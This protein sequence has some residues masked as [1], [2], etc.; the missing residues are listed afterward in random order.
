MSTS[1]IT[2]TIYT[3]SLFCFRREFN[4]RSVH[5]LTS[6]QQPKKYSSSVKI[7]DSFPHPTAYKY[8]EE[9]WHQQHGASFVVINCKSSDIEYPEH[10]TPLSIKCAFGGKEYYH[11]KNY[12]LAVT[13]ETFLILNEGTTYRSSIHSENITESFTLNFTKENIDQVSSCHQYETVQLLDEPFE[14][15]TKPIRFVEKLY[16]RDERL[17]RFIHRLRNMVNEKN[18]PDQSYIEI[19]YEVL[20][21]MV[22][23]NEEINKDIDL[24]A[25]KKRSTK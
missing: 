22:S 11:F 23:F 20:G 6:M 2:I 8:N 7:I 17:A 18:H 3:K 5:R 14:F 16:Y 13:D 12:S 1:A 15:K 24:I 10:W 21:L 4:F 9:L 25:A 19:L